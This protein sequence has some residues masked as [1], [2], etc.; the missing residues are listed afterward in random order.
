MIGQG[1]SFAAFFAFAVICLSKG[2]IGAPSIDFVAPPI[3]T[4]NTITGEVTGF[5]D[6]TQFKILI[7]VSNDQTTWWDKTHVQPNGKPQPNPVQAVVIASDG[8]FK[9]PNWAGNPDSNSVNQND[10]V[11]T[12]IGL[13]VVPNSFNTIWPTYQVEGAPIPASITSVAVCS[14]IKNRN[15]SQTSVIP[16]DVVSGIQHLRMGD[17][18]FVISPNGKSLAAF[19]VVNPG[20]K[21]VDNLKAAGAH[22]AG[23]VYLVLIKRNGYDVASNR[24]V[25]SKAF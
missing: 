7:L 24:I 6:P 21:M 11:T 10:L 23:G 14:L 5:T 13:W 25:V 22:C 4:G 8:T 3:G 1:R 9:I 16:R 20:L 17:E 15:N 12:Y 18:V 2:A 19:K